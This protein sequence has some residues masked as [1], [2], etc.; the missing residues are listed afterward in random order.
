MED[1]IRRAQGWSDTKVTNIQRNLIPARGFLSHGLRILFE[2][3]DQIHFFGSAFENPR[4][5]LLLWFATRLGIDCY[6]ISEPYSPVPLGYFSDESGWIVKLKTWLRPT[7]YR[8]YMLVL[9]NRLSGIFAISRLAYQ[10]FSEAGVPPSRLFP[11]GYFVPS[12]I[13]TRLVKHDS[14]LEKRP[15]ALKLVFVGSLIRRKGLETLITAI[16]LAIDRGAGLQLDV[17][18]PGNPVLFGFDEI[19]VRYLGRIPF[20]KTQHILTS[21]DLLVLPSHYDGWGVVVNEALCAGVPVLC[22]D[23]VGARVLIE[24]FG[25]GQVFPQGDV[26]KLADQLVALA[27]NSARMQAMKSACPT[28]AKNIQP[29]RAA[30]YMLQV[31]SAV[32]DMRA[33]IPSPWYRDVAQ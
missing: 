25:T 29:T 16:Q 8:F 24:C 33:T 14:L 26:Q 22:S 21:Y 1:D 15:R 18:G 6:I 19:S 2:N 23:Q 10:Q 27:S 13:E 32:P 3:S 31:L 30:R 9:R 12:E 11:F 4:M 5:T 7:L 20:G 17:F 28:A